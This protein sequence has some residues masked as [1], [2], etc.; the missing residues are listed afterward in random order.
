MNLLILSS[1]KHLD[2]GRQVIGQ[3]LLRTTASFSNFTNHAVL[4]QL[5]TSAGRTGQHLQEPVLPAIRS[6]GQLVSVL[7]LSSCLAC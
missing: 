5:V 1:I 3:L 4:I 7:L 6:A 2:S